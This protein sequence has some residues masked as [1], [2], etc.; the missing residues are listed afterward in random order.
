MAVNLT[1]LASVTTAASALT[2]LIMVTPQSVVGYA[3]QNPNDPDGSVSI[4]QNA[5]AILFHYEG[6]QSV[7]L[8]SDIT[9]H[10]VEDN[11]A[12][13]DQIALK[14]IMVT[15][16]GF[17]GELNNVPPLG[18]QTLK[19][20][21]DKLTI[22]GPY[23]P[24]LSITAQLAYNEAFLAY[25]SATKLA[26]AAVSAWSSVSNAVSGS[27]G[28]AVI[29]AEGDLTLGSVQNEQQKYFQQFYGYWVK[30]TLFTVQTPWAVFEN[31]AILNLR[32]IQ[33]AETN[34]ITDFEVS[35]K[36]IRNAFSAFS[37]IPTSFA[38]RSASQAQ[39]KTNQGISAG[40][41][42]SVTPASATST[43]LSGGAS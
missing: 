34:V 41:P 43:T 6:E 27:D 21:A 18:L 23:T 22:I 35:F 8:Q 7:S 16:H 36:Q 9:D 39:T 19:T 12:V 29:D 4:N 20:A 11:T 33:D 10:F 13:Q 15:T 24:Q 30:K 2:G 25:Q 26:N 14:P 40:T 42:T 5:P 38:G 17:I 28:N 32:A 1:A 3:P 37:G 31:M